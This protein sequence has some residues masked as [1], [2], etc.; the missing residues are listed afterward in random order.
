MG[1]W[2]LWLAW[3]GIAWWRWDWDDLDDGEKQRSNVAVVRYIV[4]L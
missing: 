1:G 2:R 4:V 3:H